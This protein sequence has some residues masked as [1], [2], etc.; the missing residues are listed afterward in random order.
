MHRV[1]LTVAC[2]IATGEIIRGEFL[3]VYMI[4]L[5]NTIR[6]T[7]MSEL[8]LGSGLCYG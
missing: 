1:T 5:T 2:I 6:V 4:Y 3:F 7:Y 8:G